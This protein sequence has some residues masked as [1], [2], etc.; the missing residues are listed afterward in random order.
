MLSSAECLD[1]L[2]NHVVDPIAHRLGFTREQTGLWSVVVSSVQPEVNPPNR[3]ETADPFGEKE[4][5][6]KG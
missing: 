1:S 4:R 3:Y 2:L 6:K 5:K